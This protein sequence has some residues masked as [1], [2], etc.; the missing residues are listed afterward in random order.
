MQR[1]TSCFAHFR[2]PVSMAPREASRDS[3]FGSQGAQKAI[4]NPSGP[5]TMRVSENRDGG[6]NRESV[7]HG[8]LQ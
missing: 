5:A 1:G 2:D 7:E 4:E 8:K 3:D 6:G